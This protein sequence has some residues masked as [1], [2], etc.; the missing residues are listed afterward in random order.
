MTD[1]GLVSKMYKE[2]IKLNTQRT[3]HPIMKRADDM[4]RRFTKEDLQ[5]INRHVKKNA[6]YHSS[7]GK[8]ESKPQ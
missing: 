4:N 1:E 8:Y 2:V 6:A 5:V 3:D 7:S